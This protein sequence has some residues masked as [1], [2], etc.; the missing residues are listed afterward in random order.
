MATMKSKHLS[1]FGLVTFTFLYSGFVMAGGGP[2]PAANPFEVG[3]GLNLDEWAK[4]NAIKPLNLILSSNVASKLGPCGCSV[5]PKGGVDR[6]FNF[7]QSKANVGGET[8][9]LDAGNALFANRH[10]DPSLALKQRTRARAI[11]ASQKALGIEVQNVGVVDL[12]AGLDFALEVKKASG[13]KMISTN[14]VREDGV[15]APFDTFY[16]KEVAGLGK[17][18][19]LGVMALPEEGLSGLKV[20]DAVEAVQAQIKNQKPK[21][22]VVLS[23]LGQSEDM[24][25]MVKVNEPMIVV[26]ARDLNSIDIPLHAGKGIL[27]QPGIQGQQTGLF[28]FAAP[29]D[30]VA[31]RNLTQDKALSQRWNQLV[32]EYRAVKEQDSSDDKKKSLERIADSFEE[33]SKYASTDLN[34]S[35]PYAYELYD[36][37]SRYAQKNQFTKQA[38]EDQ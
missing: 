26:G 16:T 7:I 33:L 8:L 22:T 14:L 28:R 35:W 1:L 17:V 2:R 15:T 31:W 27:V 38:L 19:V 20:L 9:I 37:D 32:N 6:R 24:R 21:I 5:N 18:L 13:L 30:F 12:A 10:V 23:D 25:M 29:K 4:T 36:M 11:A 34:K 3:A